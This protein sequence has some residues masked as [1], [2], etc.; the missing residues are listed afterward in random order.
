[1]WNKVNYTKVKSKHTSVVCLFSLAVILYHKSMRYKVVLFIRLQFKSTHTWKEKPNSRIEPQGPRQF[2]TWSYDVLHTHTH[3]EGGNIF[4]WKWATASKY[5]MLKT[6]EYDAFVNFWL[7][8]KFITP[9]GDFPS[10][11][12]WRQRIKL[13]VFSKGQLLNAWK[14]VC[15]RKRD[16]VFVHKLTNM[17]MKLKMWNILF[18]KAFN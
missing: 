11:T 10:S 18:S 13:L 7:F 15:G 17:E 6:L 12:T 3:V 16:R 1:M 4:R 2:N 5:K 14:C 9:L 8:N